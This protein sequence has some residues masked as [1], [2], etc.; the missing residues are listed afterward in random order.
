M[1]WQGLPFGLPC[2]SG[3]CVW[4]RITQDSGL[5]V[6]SVG[7]WDRITDVSIEPRGPGPADPVTVVVTGRKSA[8]NVGLQR[9]E[10]RLEGERFVLDVSWSDD[11][12][13]VVLPGDYPWTWDP[14][15]TQTNYTYSYTLGTHSV[16][17]HALVIK[18][19]REG[20]I[21]AST[22]L[23]FTVSASARDGRSLPDRDLDDFTHRSLQGDDLVP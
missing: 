15:Q 18:H 2:G 22:Y 5:C 4:G 6:R 3:A 1:S 17:T 7:W 23:L 10:L 8:P 21:C 19:W 9:K 14:L 12:P 20:C 16:G 13:L 11:E